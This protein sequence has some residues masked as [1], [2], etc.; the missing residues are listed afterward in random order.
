MLQGVSLVH[1]VVLRTSAGEAWRCYKERARKVRAN[2]NCPE[3]GDVHARTFVAV[4]QHLLELRGTIKREAPRPSGVAGAASTRILPSAPGGRE[5][6]S[7][8]TPSISGAFGKG[9]SEN[10][11]ESRPRSVNVA[12]ATR[13]G[14]RCCVPLTAMDPGADGGVADR[15][16]REKVRP[17]SAF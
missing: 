15:I 9:V 3:G 7:A 11:P 13:M 1:A 2:G 5:R 6:I 14:T 17:R 16:R 12:R 4:R 8:S 10:Q